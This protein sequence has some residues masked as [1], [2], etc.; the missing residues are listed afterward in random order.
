MAKVF[1]IP[2][3]HLKYW[4][5]EEA[6]N[7]LKTISCDKVVLLGDLVDDWYQESNLKL[8][9][10]TLEEAI[11]FMKDHDA[12][13]CY[14]NHDVS[15]KWEMQES[16]YSNKARNT[17]L[18]GLNRLENC[19][20]PER[21]AFAHRIDQTVFSHA[22][23]LEEYVT[24]YLSDPYMDM[25]EAIAEINEMGSDELWSDISP[26]WARPQDAHSGMELFHSE[27][28]QVVGHTPVSEP[29]QQGNLLTLDTFSTYPDGRPIG[30]ERF[31]IVD[32]V[33]GSWEYAD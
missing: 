23:I 6:R 5:F 24:E 27:L 29:L 22:G 8:Y 3:V 1:V 7:L 14:G 19:V 2:D 9:E 21:I 16:G 28:F 30:D 4:M 20:S 15:Y 18:N 33:D 31:V 12:L 10:K 13:F 32:T 17:V 25:D 26:I 11:K